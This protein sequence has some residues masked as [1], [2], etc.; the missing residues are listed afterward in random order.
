MTRTFLEKMFAKPAYVKAILHAPEKIKTLLFIESRIDNN[1]TASYDFILAFYIKKTEL[2]REVSLLKSKLNKNGLL[3]IAYPK[4]KLLQTDL[5][6]DRLHSLLRNYDLD[7]VSLISL[8]ETW[9]AMRF[10][11]M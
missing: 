1:L 4:N 9:S 6:R 3:W 10:K 2:E 5:N 8:S 7:G 11:Q